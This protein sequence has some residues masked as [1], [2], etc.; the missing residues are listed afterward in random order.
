MT[1]DKTNVRLAEPGERP[2]IGAR[3]DPATAE[4]NFIY[5]Q[6]LDPYGELERLPE[7]DCVGREWFA[8]DPVE[9]IWVSFCDLPQATRDAPEDK[10]QAAIARDGSR[11][12]RQSDE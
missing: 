10:R 4:V 11:S 5:A 12:S 3:I 2:T 6:V 7:E 1:D 9:R 8:A